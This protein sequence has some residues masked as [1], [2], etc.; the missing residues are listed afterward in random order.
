M[1]DRNTNGTFATGNPGGPGRPR[2][3]VEREYLGAMLDA[4][5]L[6]DWRTIIGKAVEDAKS[7]N[8]KA[9]D[10]LAR[11]VLGPEPLKPSEMAADEQDLTPEEEIESTRKRRSKQRA[12]AERIMTL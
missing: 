8:S 5:S 4:I 3:T 11:Y 6:D 10:W 1:A 7:G 2:R 9:R 12:F